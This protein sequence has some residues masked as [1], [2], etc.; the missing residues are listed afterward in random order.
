MATQD[1][2]PRQVELVGEDWHLVGEEGEPA[3]ENSWT[4]YTAN[5]VAG[6]GW[7]PCSFR[8]DPSG[9]VM[10]RGLVK[11]G[12]SAAATVFTLPK[13]YRPANIPHTGCVADGE[14]ETTRCRIY[15]D[16]QV[17]FSSDAST[18]WTDMNGVTF[19]ADH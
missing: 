2:E 10:L 1:I 5:P 18:S 7:S 3:F 12:S 17:K 11:S 9:L 13:G 6:S 8:K 15:S 16:G 19:Y 14:V 4:N